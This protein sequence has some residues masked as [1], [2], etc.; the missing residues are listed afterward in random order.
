MDDNTNYERFIVYNVLN[1]IA[2]VFPCKI[3][4]WF[5]YLEDTKISCH[6]L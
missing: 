3:V 5:V 4:Y 1:K 2:L 6:V